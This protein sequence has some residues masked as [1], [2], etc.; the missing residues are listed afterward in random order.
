LAGRLF[1]AWYE[2]HAFTSDNLKEIVQELI[3]EAGFTDLS[4]LVVARLI[5]HTL[6]RK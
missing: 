3:L 2:E 1:G 5:H 4:D 6:A